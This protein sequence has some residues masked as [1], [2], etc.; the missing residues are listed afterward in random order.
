M[1]LY[2]CVRFQH[3]GQTWYAREKYP[4]VFYDITFDPKARAYAHVATSSRSN[5]VFGIADTNDSVPYCQEQPNYTGDVGTYKIN[6]NTEIM[7]ITIHL[8]FI[9]FE[10]WVFAIVSRI[11]TY[12][13]QGAPKSRLSYLPPSSYMTRSDSNP[14]VDSFEPQPPTHPH[15]PGSAQCW[16]QSY[17]YNIPEDAWMDK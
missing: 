16:S 11:V 14:A 8:F 15:P 17:K 9:E 13:Y 3:W 6:S 12:C 4:S 10:H 7:Q 5:V 1:G 2:I